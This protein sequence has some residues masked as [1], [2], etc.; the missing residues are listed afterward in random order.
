MQ[1]VSRNGALFLN[2]RRCSIRFV[3]RCPSFYIIIFTGSSP[4]TSYLVLE[5]HSIL[6]SPPGRHS[7]SSDQEIS[8]SSSLT[9]HIHWCPTILS[10]SSPVQLQ[11][12]NRSK[13][14]DV[15]R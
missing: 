9:F 5:F 15:Q 12:I 3:A 11:R 1:N 2:R 8:L 10:Y 13:R 6:P 4:T 7:L 14:D